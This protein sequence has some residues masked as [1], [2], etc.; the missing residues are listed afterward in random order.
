MI[1]VFGGSFDPPH[2]GHLYII[3][4]FWKNFKDAEKLI[5]VPNK[6]SPFKKQKNT[7]PRHILKMLELII[8]ESENPN[9]EIDTYEADREGFSYTAETLEYLKEKYSQELCLL[10]GLDNL[11]SFPKWKDFRKILHLSRL[12]VFSR[13]GADFLIPPELNEFNDKITYIKDGMFLESST[14]IRS[15]ETD[16]LKSVPKESAEYIRRNHL[17]GY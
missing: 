9:T 10:I 12:A 6:V 4:S 1:G 3:K 16:L 15:H 5:I 7:E 17:Y 2:N 14:G 11:K 8:L 13:P